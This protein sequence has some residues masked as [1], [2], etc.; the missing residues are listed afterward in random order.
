MYLVVT[1]LNFVI[2]HILEL[3]IRKKKYIHVI[4]MPFLIIHWLLMF[5]LEIR[6]KKLKRVSGERNK[7]KK[8]TMKEKKNWN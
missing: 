1:I 6:Y 3:T 8:N 2:P 4:L 5:I 7:P